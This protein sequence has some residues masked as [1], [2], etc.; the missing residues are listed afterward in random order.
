MPV[1]TSVRRTLTGAMRRLATDGAL[2]WRNVARQRHRSALALVAVVFGVAAYMLAA[3]FID[4]SLWAGRE[5]TIRAHLG[6]LQVARKGYFDTGAADPWAFVIDPGAGDDRI[7]RSVGGV[8]EVAPRL[9]FSGLAGLGDATLSFL[10]EGVDPSREGGL[11]RSVSIE[12]GQ[13]LDAG[14]PRGVILGRGLAV[15]LGAKVGDTIVLLANTRSG[16]VNAVEARVRGLFSTVT[17]AYDDHAL[18]APLAL[19]QELLRVSGVHKWVVLLDKTESTPRALASLGPRLEARGLEVVPWF[20]LADFY[21]KTAELFK[22]QVGFVKLITA[23]IIVLSISNAMMMAVMERTGEIGTALALGATRAQI[24]RQ[25]VGEGLLIGLAGG[26]LGVLLGVTLAGAISAIGIP[27]PPGPGMT[28]SYVAEIA[29]SW[30]LSADAALLALA[31]AFVASLYPAWKA[32]A[33]P[34]VDALRQSR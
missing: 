14:D 5:W 16:G 33:L 12:Q 13:A 19:A 26:F 8:S 34:I 15:N 20:R 7:L 25:F 30:T 29:V 1:L 24:L 10:G 2:A 18:R 17:K 6:H 9:A 32:A 23:I 27:M 11:A 4:W 28:Q 31:T 3:G 22:R 21:N